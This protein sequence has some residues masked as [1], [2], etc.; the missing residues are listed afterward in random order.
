MN[1]KIKKALKIVSKPASEY[2]PAY[3]IYEVVMGTG[4][5]EKY[6]HG[7]Q[8][9]FCENCIDNA[10]IEKKRKYFIERQQEMG[11]IYEFMQKGYFLQPVYKWNK[12]GRSS[13]IMIQKSLF[14]RLLD[15]DATL[16]HLQNQLRK[17][18]PASMKFDKIN[19][20][21]SGEH[22]GFELCESCG[23]IFQQ[24]LI[25]D[26]QELEHW[27]DFDNTD[28]NAAI[29]KPHTAYQLDYILNC[30]SDNP[31]YCK[32]QKQLIALAERIISANKI[33]VYS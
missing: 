16:K 28:M 15:K 24:G 30:W 21:G 2:K 3:D 23:I 18:Y 9:T 32:Y 13:G 12:E 26:R 22:D 20:G 6:P 25:L 31:E 29:K 17:K 5:H 27:A 14:K 1:A 11:K 7:S 8:E 10:V 33:N 4:N 19:Y